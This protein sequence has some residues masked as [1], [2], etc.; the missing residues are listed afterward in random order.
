MTGPDMGA[1]LPERAVRAVRWSREP[2]KQAWMEAHDRG[3]EAALLSKEFE[4]AFGFPLAGPQVSLWRSTNGR[5]ARRSHGGG[6]PPSP[7]GSERDSGRGYVLVKVA[8]HPR[9]PQSKDNW[10]MKHVLAYERAHGPVPEGCVV[11]FADRDHSNF[12]PGNLVAVP[13][14]PTR[15]EGSHGSATRRWPRRRSCASG[16]SAPRPWRTGCAGGCRRSGSCSETT[17][18]GRR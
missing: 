11:V 17:G 3:Q 9:V 2:E 18:R 1:A 13:R 16:P 10:R 15:S 4:G 6:K 8:E 7:V 14:S 5:Q 12:S